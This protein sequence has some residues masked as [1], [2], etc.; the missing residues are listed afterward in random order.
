MNRFSLALLVLA[1][2]FLLA[3]HSAKDVP[4]KTPSTETTPA[5]SS[6]SDKK[7]GGDKKKPSYKAAWRVVTV[8]K[9]IPLKKIL[10]NP[11][12]LSMKNKIKVAMDIMLQIASSAQENTARKSLGADGIVVRIGTN[13]KNRRMIDGMVKDLFVPPPTTN[14]PTLATVV[15]K[16]HTIRP[17]RGFVPPALACKGKIS[18]KEI[19]SADQFSLGCTF[20]QMYFGKEPV[21]VKLS[22]EPASG[23]KK[24]KC[25]SQ[26]FFINLIRAGKQRELP[27]TNL[28]AQQKFLRTILMMT[29]PSAEGRGSPAMAYAMLYEAYTGHPLPQDK[30]E[31]KGKKADKKTTKHQST[32]K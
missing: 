12:A 23:S 8:E 13:L 32:K 27:K 1:P 5:Q 17:K 10:K 21:W 14:A 20:W 2:M 24:E 25:R 15:K 31:D 7:K 26:E 29:N 3:G 11:H 18:H 9:E 19:S 6:P 4:P 28:S 16:S 30:K 22:K